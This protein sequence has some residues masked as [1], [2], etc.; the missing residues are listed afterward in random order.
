M[1]AVTV[2]RRHT[3]RFSLKRTRNKVQMIEDTN[4]SS[5]AHHSISEKKILLLDAVLK[6]E[7]AWKFADWQTG[8]TMTCSA[9][10][11]VFIPYAPLADVHSECATAK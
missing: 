11:S 10:D 1:T 7:C 5:D 8:K 4:N 9:F 2:T 6:C 3:T